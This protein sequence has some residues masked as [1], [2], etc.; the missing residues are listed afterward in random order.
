MIQDSAVCGTVPVCVGVCACGHIECGVIIHAC[1]HMCRHVHALHNIIISKHS[2][3]VKVI[4][5]P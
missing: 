3:E 1:A 5:F 4:M 2:N